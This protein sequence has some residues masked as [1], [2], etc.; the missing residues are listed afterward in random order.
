MLFSLLISNYFFIV[1]LKYDSVFGYDT[2]SEAEF[3]RHRECGGLELAAE[4]EMTGGCLC[5]GVFT[6]ERRWSYAFN[7][8]MLK[9]A[10]FFANLGLV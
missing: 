9:S 7:L 3:W 5:D 10:N 2:V 6:A 1:C 4:E 8:D